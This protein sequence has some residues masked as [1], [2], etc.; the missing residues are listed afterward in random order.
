MHDPSSCMFH[1]TQNRGERKS[2]RRHVWFKTGPSG[3][4]ILLL[5]EYYY[6]FQI[7][8]SVAAFLDRQIWSQVDGDQQFLLLYFTWEE[9]HLPWINIHGCC[10]KNFFQYGYQWHIL[11][12]QRCVCVCVMKLFTDR[13][14][15]EKFRQCHSFRFVR[16]VPCD[17][18]LDEIGRAR[19]PIQTTISLL[20]WLMV[21]LFH[22]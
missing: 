16:V 18:L 20:R 22:Q 19:P 9:Q 1:H 7:F 14:V 8:S 10:T 21:M 3:I 2:I 11:I 15:D 13:S 4:G 12:V 5:S 17:F 6:F